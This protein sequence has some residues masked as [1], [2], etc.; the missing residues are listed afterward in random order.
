MA[1]FRALVPSMFHRR[2]ILLMGSAIGVCGVLVL[3][4]GNLTVVRGAEHLA[5]AESRLV[6]VRW[7]ETVRGRV[8]DRKGR[9]LAQDGASF[10]VLVDYRVIK[11]E[12]AAIKAREDVLR[13]QR[14]QWDMLDDVGRKGL[15]ESSIPRYQEFLEQK[16][17][18]LAIALRVERDELD[19]ARWDVIERIHPMGAYVRELQRSA[20]EEE[21]N[22][23]RRVAIPVT[24]GDVARP[25]A[26]EREAHALARGVSSEVAADVRRLAGG[27][28]GM[29]GL[30]VRPSGKREYPYESM[31]VVLDGEGMPSRLREQMDGAVLVRTAGVA[32]HV[33]G[34]MRKAQREDFDRRAANGAKNDEDGPDR[35]YYREGDLVGAGGIEEAAED[36]LR[37]TRGRIVEHH[38][39]ETAEIAQPASGQDVHLTLDI[40]LQARIQALMTPDVGLAKVQPWHASSQGLAFAVGTPLNGAAVVI[41]IESGEV[42]AMVSTPSFTRET[43]EEFSVEMSRNEVDAPLVNKAVGKPYPPGS[44]VKPLVLTWAVTDGEFRMDEGIECTGAL[45]PERAPKSLRCWIYKQ[46]GHT[47]SDDFGGALGGDLAIEVSCNIFFYTLGRRLGFN[48]MVEWFQQMGVGEGFS[49][50][51]GGEYGGYVGDGGD[52]QTPRVTHATF[53]GIGQGP[54]DW[55]PLHA[56]DAYATLARGGVRI[57]PRVMRGL[58]PRHKDLHWD[59]SAVEM[60]MSGLDGVVNGAAATGRWLTDPDTGVREPIFNAPGINIWGKTGTADAP[61]IYARGADGKRIMVETANP[62]P[63]QSSSMPKALREGD[64]SWFVV[65]A[66][67]EGYPKYSIAVL[68][69]YGG[70][71][72]RVSGPITNQIVHALIDEGYLHGGG[73]GG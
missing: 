5:Q 46:F 42:L 49:L 50:G 13:E 36:V 55:T 73:A 45:Y 21:M 4:A 66:G 52:T 64:H 71:G 40:Q 11:G 41:E 29:P 32:T 17:D 33:L 19:E 20:R 60:A 61:A 2:L 18:A 35:G 59:S 38:D 15:I 58:M 1:S 23:D 9:V 65:L 48:R 10:D 16:W 63:G 51:I 24:L 37:G 57:W 3:Q 28:N 26:E 39:S 27:E 6:S 25:I 68:I 70:S 47:H 62:Q 7:T 72:G 8:L 12:W 54:V 30:M 31:E 56:A 43:Y 67:D 44:V 22:R 69:E 14:E 53:M 34:R